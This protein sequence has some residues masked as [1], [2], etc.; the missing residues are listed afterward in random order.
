MGREDMTLLKAATKDDLLQLKEVLTNSLARPREA[1]LQEGT[2][3]LDI[4]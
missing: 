3:G 2:S 4:L 1:H